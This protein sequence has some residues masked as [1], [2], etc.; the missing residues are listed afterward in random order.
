[1]SELTARQILER[2]CDV[3]PY[4]NDAIP[5]DI[6]V[7]VIIDGKYV[8][9]IPADDLNLGTQIGSPVNPGA[10]R[11]AIETGL[12]VTR[13]IPKEKSA[14]GMAYLASA[15]PFKDGNT[16]VGC[17]TIT[18]STTAID[19]INGVSSE[20]AASSEE[21]TA[22]M[23]ELASRA[24]E[25]STTAA[26]LDTLSKKLLDSARQ[27]DEIVGFIKTVAGQTNLLGLNAAIEAARVGE[28]GRG[29]GVVAEEV[30]KLAVASSDS[31][32]RISQSLATIY[33][34]SNSLAQMSGNIDNNIAGQT[35]AIQEMAK[36]SQSLAEHASKLSEAL[37]E[38]FELNK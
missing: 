14:Y 6:G 31:V 12:P 32:T 33:E 9:Y 19:R 28:M 23:E 30:R 22:G 21:L 29:F 36:F 18:Q 27:T 38:M 2:F 1:M 34:L 16:V 20:V 10:S 24:A 3:A 17:V 26:Q 13:V 11:Q 35:T 15:L 7:S 37:Q 25:V 5:G 4:L 8:T